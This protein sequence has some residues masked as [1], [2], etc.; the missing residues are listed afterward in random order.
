MTASKAVRADP[1]EIGGHVV[2]PGQRD[3]FDMP[4]ALLPTHT[5]L[6]IPLTV[7]HGLRK[8]PVL[9][10][11]AV[12]HGDELNGLEVIRR[13]LEKIDGPLQS[14]TV[15]AAPIVNVFG[16]IGQSRYMP[17]RRD[18]NRS[19]PGSRT[20]SLAAR[21]ADLFLRQ[22]I[23]RATHCIDIHT[24]AQDKRNLGQIRGDLRDPET[25]RL[26]RAFGAPVMLQ[27]GTRGG[28]MRSAAIKLGIKAV[29]YEAGEPLRFNEPEIKI[30]ER[31][32]LAVMRE[33]G[34][35]KVGPKIQ[36]ARSV[37]LEESSWIR[38]RR[39]GLMRLSV[40]VG[41]VVEAKQRIGTISDPFGEE[42]VSVRA[43]FRGIVI[44][45]TNNPVVHGGDALVHVGK[46]G[47]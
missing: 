5:Q 13:V 7:I 31:G 30:G 22:I 26:A 45:K 42:S 41:T 10:L 4:A 21:I 46:L 35:R 37:L 24:A 6:H 3:R 25:L 14:G 43:P 44:G 12:V 15:I 1:F 19:F 27:S 9:C 33:L 36:P 11:S 39:G 8:G 38:A 20:G 29:V 47:T 16:F 18:L 28:S 23:A 32:V 34:M 17:D 2:L 40:D